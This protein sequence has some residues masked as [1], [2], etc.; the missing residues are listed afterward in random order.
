VAKKT[1]VDEATGV[2]EEVEEVEAAPEREYTQM[3]LMA[4]A[5][6]ADE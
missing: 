5:K 6:P 1:I 3:E 4:A 2:Q